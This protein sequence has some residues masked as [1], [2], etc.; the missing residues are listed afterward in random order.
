MKTKAATYLGYFALVT[1]A[2]L[3]GNWAYD[4]FNK[5]KSVPPATTTGS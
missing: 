1:A 4:Q 3:V 2:V 5:P